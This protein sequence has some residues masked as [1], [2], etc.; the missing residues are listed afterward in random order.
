[1]RT[2]KRRHRSS[3]A[4]R[5]DFDFLTF[6]AVTVPVTALVLAM[7]ILEKTLAISAYIHIQFKS[8]PAI[9]QVGAALQPTRSLPALGTK[10]VT[11]AL[12]KC[13]KLGVQ[14]SGLAAGK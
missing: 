1:M 8:L 2:R 4:K 13:R 10:L 11:R 7:E 14:A 5:D 12:F 6:I 9:A 3:Q